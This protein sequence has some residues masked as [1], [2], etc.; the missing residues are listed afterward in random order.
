MTRLVLLVAAAL[1]HAVGVA[2]APVTVE[3]ADGT[4]HA[5]PPAGAGPA[6][7]LL[8]LHGYRQSGAGAVAD[9]G[10]V[11]ASAEAGAL[12]VAP[13]GRGQTWS[14]VGSPAHDRDDLAFLAAVVADAERR[15]PV[16]RGRV[17]AAGFSQGASMVW[18][19]ACHRA[20]GF[21]A[22]LSVS[23]AF[24][25]PYPE[26]CP[27]GPVNLRHV[28]GLDDGV[29]PIHGRTILERFTQGDLYRSFDILR[30][31]DGCAAEPDR[32]DRD[33]VLE[34][35]AWSSCASGRQLVLVLHPGGHVM[36]PAF[37]RSG[38]AWAL[39]LP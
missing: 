36:D 29:M 18:D 33:G 14:H 38:L 15:W 1:L 11:A 13:D 8:Y 3:L 27:T 12:F 35:Q 17:V 21:R 20:G 23:G 19:L 25:L 6:P 34:L 30:R 5:V 2:A 16:D 10:L 37:L 24:W 4:Y 39:A 9:P 31:L 7:M 26:R 22:F 28:H 32:V